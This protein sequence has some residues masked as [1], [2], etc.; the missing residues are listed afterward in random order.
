MTYPR[1]AR[2][3]LNILMLKENKVDIKRVFLIV[4]DSFG[5]GELDDAEKY[6]DKGSNTLLSVAKSEKFNCPNFK[7]L[8]LFNIDGVNCEMG[9]DAPLSAYG[10]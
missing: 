6:G 9:V 7:S 10:R 5:I 3:Y 1:D 2:R 8:G 4:L